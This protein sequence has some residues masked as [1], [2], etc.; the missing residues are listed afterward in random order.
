MAFIEGITIFCIGASYAVALA[1][2]LVQLLRP[3]R[4]QRVAGTAF[5]LA[6]LLAHTLLLV[7]TFFLAEQPLSLASQTGSLLFLSWILAVFYLYGSLHHRSFSWGVFILPLVLGLVVLAGM[8]GP[9][10]VESSGIGTSPGAQL[11]L[12]KWSLDW[13]L[14]HG[15][16]LLLAAVGV[17][18]G[19]VASIMYLVQVRRLRAKV[20]PGHGIRLLSLERLEEMNRRAIILSFPLLTAG[21]LVGLALMLEQA[22]G[23]A[24]LNLPKILSTIILWVV[25]AIL[26]YLRYGMHARGR[27]VAFMTIVAF[28]LLLFTLVSAHHF[29]PEGMP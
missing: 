15:A 4:V 7:R 3:R 29:G 19:F 21:L 14:I 18:V 26:L 9:A 5:G 6:G 8:F 16:L 20:P 28:G 1:L 11:I 25:F 23:F 22:D 12:G 27:R 17:C 10:S 13:G 2:E 24:Q